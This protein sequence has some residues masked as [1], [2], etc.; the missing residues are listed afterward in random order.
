MSA[1]GVGC[2]RG[3]GGLMVGATGGSIR[4]VTCGGSSGGC[5]TGEAGSGQP[6]EVGFS[7][8][9]QQLAS[10]VLRSFLAVV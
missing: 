9:V 1:A 6:L 7:G 5:S 2:S 3:E 10:K 8:D 4:S